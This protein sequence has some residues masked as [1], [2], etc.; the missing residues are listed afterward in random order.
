LH[1][2]EPLLSEEEPLVA[3][4]RLFRCTGCGFEGELHPTERERQHPARA[5]R[6][7]EPEE[8]EEQHQPR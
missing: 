4:R 1:D 6:P 7:I 2:L 3:P 8:E 5:P